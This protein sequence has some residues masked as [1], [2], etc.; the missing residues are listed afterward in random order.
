[1]DSREAGQSDLLQG[2]TVPE[3]GISD[4]FQPLGETDGFQ[5]AA[6]AERLIPD[7][8]QGVGRDTSRRPKRSSNRQ[9]GIRRV[10]GRMVTF[11]ILQQPISQEKGPVTSGAAS[12]YSSACRRTGLY[13]TAIP[14]LLHGFGQRHLLK[15]LVDKGVLGQLDHWLSPQGLRNGQSGV[16]ILPAAGE[17]HAAGAEHLIGPVPRLFRRPAPPRR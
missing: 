4:G 16:F 5:I 3:G 12:P 15:Q 7:L 6:A 1:M 9:P 10:P 14:Q 2:V 11:W 8:L 17:E 13:Q